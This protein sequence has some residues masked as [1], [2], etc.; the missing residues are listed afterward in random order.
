MKGSLSK[1]LLPV[2]IICAFFI[3][4]GCNKSTPGTVPTLLTEDV[5]I[6]AA[7]TSAQSGG[8]V[9]NYND[10]YL[11]AVG[12][13]WSATNKTPT[14][15]DS[16]SSDTLK[17]PSFVSD[18]TTLTAN[19]TYYV[20]AYATNTTG[21]G[22]GSVVQFNTGPD[23]S[24]KYGTVSTFAGNA[25]AGLVN[26]TGTNAQ[27]NGP[28]SI[29]M[30]SKGNFYVADSF[31]STIRKITPAGVVSN[32]AGTGVLGYANGPAATAQFYAIADLAIDAQDN[33]YVADFGNNLIRKITAAG[34]VS[35]LAGNGVN[36]YD[37]ETIGST[38][39][40]SSPRGIAV[41]AS[42]NVFVADQG[43]S[44]IRKITPAGAVS[45]YSGIQGGAY[46]DGDITIAHFNRP[47]GIAIDPTTGILYVA[48]QLN[49]AIRKVAVDGTVTT[50]LGS[51]LRT[52]KLN[53]PVAISINAKG[54]IYV[55]DQTGRI[56]VIN[57]NKTIYPIAGAA[58]TYG[59]ADGAGATAQF[60]YP[61]GLTTDA[62]GNVYVA[63]L[64][65]NRI[66]KI[67]QQ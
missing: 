18:L 2:Y 33:I 55:T 23:M 47:A 25:T 24:A 10:S 53:S 48:D 11:T 3:F 26:S 20:R 22:Y 61:Q 35:T 67:V 51:P 41:D 4:N 19:T 1:I 28:Q 21:T 42:G 32:Y 13:C 12:V 15:S 17:V 56:L 45:T 49:H 6:N 64:N 16:H 5:T 14:I 57:A 50:L 29:V 65:N 44:V 37:N 38:A 36:G 46:V 63:D 59:F 8:L 54:I 66:R 60:N 27:F 9:T 52:T 62:S 39:K 58:N 30:D 7:A 31:N 34:V 43:N 40:F